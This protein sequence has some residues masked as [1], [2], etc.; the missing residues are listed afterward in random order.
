MLTHIEVQI[1]DSRN[2][3]KKITAASMEDI[4]TTVDEDHVPFAY[5]EKLGN[6][7]AQA[8]VTHRAQQAFDLERVVKLIGE[9]VGFHLRITASDLQRDVELVRRRKVGAH[10][11]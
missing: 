7:I 10:V 3:V 4:G 1:G 5:E 2:L 8:L 11:E 6:T 9:S